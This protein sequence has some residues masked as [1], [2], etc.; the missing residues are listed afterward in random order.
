MKKLWTKKNIQTGLIT[1]IVCVIFGSA[2]AVSN[3]AAPTGP[4]NAVYQEQAA[5]GYIVRDH[6]GMVTVFEAAAPTTPYYQT[7]IYVRTL[8]QYDQ[9]LLAV[10]IA[11]VSESQLHQLLEDLGS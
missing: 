2:A 1:L 5:T 4:A 7:G 11:A 9:Q 10:G 8:R 3:H 6:D